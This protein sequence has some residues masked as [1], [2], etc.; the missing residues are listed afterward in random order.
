[1]YCMSCG[2]ENPNEAR[3]CR[4][5][6]RSL[7]LVHRNIWPV[8]SYNTLKSESEND[9]ILKSSEPAEINDKI[10]KNAS[11]KKSNFSPLWGH[12]NKKVVQVPTIQHE[13]AIETTESE[14][15][16]QSKPVQ[17]PLKVLPENF[18]SST[19][20]SR[21][22]LS[23]KPAEDFS[24]I[25]PEFIES[26]K[27]QS[28]DTNSS[29]QQ[30][31]TTQIK[32]TRKTGIQFK[33]FFIKCLKLIRLW[34][35]K[36]R[37]K[38]RFFIRKRKAAS[39]EKKQKHLLLKSKPIVQESPENPHELT[40]ETPEFQETVPIT[41]EHASDTPVSVEPI[42]INALEKALDSDSAENSANELFDCK[43]DENDPASWGEGPENLEKSHNLSVTRKQILAMAAAVIG[44]IVVIVFVCMFMFK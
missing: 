7:Q 21:K 26:P 18:E 5:C 1:M 39:A 28:P 3:Y 13:K 20:T 4:K 41:Q 16:P 22:L 30:A 42:D 9:N 25:A 19:N 27:P 2:T 10:K 15:V 31:E 12:E 36:R 8:S 40:D 35:R 43:Q 6:G 34:F 44:G 11:A 38:I 23:E 24:G 37:L 17:L 14:T 33:S 29:K 32:T